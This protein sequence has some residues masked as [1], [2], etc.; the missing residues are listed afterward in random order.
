MFKKEHVLL[1]S[2]I[3][4]ITKACLTFWKIIDNVIYGKSPD[5]SKNVFLIARY[6]HSNQN[7]VERKQ[8]FKTTQ[9]F[10]SY[11]FLG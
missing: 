4:Y 2:L 11:S 9:H 10:I 3:L 7:F 6:F 8:T 1:Q 5:V